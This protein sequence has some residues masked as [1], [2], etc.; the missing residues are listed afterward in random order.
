M[1]ELSIS[2]E[3]REN[4]VN[5][6]GEQCEGCDDVPWLHA[7]EVHILIDGQITDRIYLCSDCMEIVNE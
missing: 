1:E 7:H 4:S 2:V 3:I 5:P 6:T